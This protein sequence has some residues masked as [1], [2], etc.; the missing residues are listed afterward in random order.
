MKSVK[1][2][3][4]YAYRRNGKRQIKVRLFTDKVA[5]V[6]KLGKLNTALE[7]RPGRDDR[8]TEAAP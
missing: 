2:L 7:T 3:T 1:K 6:T 8:P 4:L 5:S